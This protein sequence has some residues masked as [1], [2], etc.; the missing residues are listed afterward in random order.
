MI[1]NM[2]NCQ[3]NVLNWIKVETLFQGNIVIFATK[4]YFI[5]I[6][7]PRTLQQHEIFE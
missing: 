5:K 6:T 7:W 1:E 2:H 3:K 4:I